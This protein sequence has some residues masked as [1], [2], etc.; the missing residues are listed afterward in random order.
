MY[1]GKSIN[2]LPQVLS[3]E[4]VAAQNGK[5]SELQ[6]KYCMSKS[7]MFHASHVQ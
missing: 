4:L 3:H 2:Q 6:K 7:T 5:S 1:N